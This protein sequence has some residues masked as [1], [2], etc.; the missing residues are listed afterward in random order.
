MRDRALTAG[1]RV[2]TGG[3]MISWLRVLGLRV[4]LL[5]TLAS[6]VLVTHLALPRTE[7]P[8]TLLESFDRAFALVY[9][10][11]ERQV[12]ELEAGGG[13]APSAQRRDVFAMLDQLA[14]HIAAACDAA[15][16]ALDIE[17]A[18]AGSLTAER[19]IATLGCLEHHLDQAR[20]SAERT[21]DPLVRAEYEA[22]CDRLRDVRRMI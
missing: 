14:D 7:L 13:P 2:T 15:T 18:L 20:R 12:A 3:R 10:A 11:A 5:C 4:A 8:F 1:S 6:V 21:G 22:T 9:D 17:L 16:A 19:R